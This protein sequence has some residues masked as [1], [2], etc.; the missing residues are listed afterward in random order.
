MWWCGREDDREGGHSSSSFT[1][2]IR[3]R[4]G[5]YTHFKKATNLNDPDEL[6]ARQ[7][8]YL[9]GPFSSRRCV[10]SGWCTWTYRGQV[11]L[12]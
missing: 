9:L 3:H 1:F 6:I 5:K 12:R 7:D 10:C 8:C 2:Q 4:R 11:H